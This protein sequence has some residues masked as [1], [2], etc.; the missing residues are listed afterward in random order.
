MFSSFVAEF[1]ATKENCEARRVDWVLANHGMR[2]SGGF[3]GGVTIA[4]GAT[5]YA[6]LSGYIGATSGARPTG[7]DDNRHI[8]II[9][10]VFHTDRT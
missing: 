4:A 9:Y 6:P 8:G 10:I 5:D 1:T 2:D 3:N 7:D